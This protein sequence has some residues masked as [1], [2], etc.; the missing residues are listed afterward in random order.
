M[1]NNS[2]L[3]ILKIRKK[4]ESSFA[5]DYC[6]WANTTKSRLIGLLNQPSLKDNEG[7]LLDP[8]NQVHMFFMPYAI[9]AIFLNASNEILGMQTLKPWRLSKLYF[10]AK[11]VLEMNAG[12]ALR[13]GWKTG[14]KIEVLN[15]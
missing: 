2:S 8:C 4:G 3:P 15:D 1:K 13:L 6:L 11:K 10:K 14:D 5:L 9:D 12:V 7:L